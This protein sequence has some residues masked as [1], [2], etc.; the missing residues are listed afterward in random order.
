MREGQKRIE[1]SVRDIKSEL[2]S[3]RHHMHAADSDNLR[4]DNRLGEIETRLEGIENRLDLT[5]A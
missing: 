5:D 1:R 4:Q 2:V 3:I